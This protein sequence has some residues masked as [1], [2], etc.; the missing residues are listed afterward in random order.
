M[1]KIVFGIVP[2]IL[3]EQPHDFPCF[4]MDLSRSGLS[5][6][7]SFQP[8]VYNSSYV[9]YYR[10]KIDEENKAKLEKDKQEEV[11]TNDKKVVE[12]KEPAKEPVK[13]ET[14][15][16]EKEETK[17]PEVTNNLSDG[18][19]KEPTTPTRTYVLLHRIDLVIKVS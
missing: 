17:S 1:L 12:S 18:N 2:F 6:G 3:H 14:P 7:V 11:Q 5:S 10:R 15:P 19:K 16:K 13:E 4:C 8:R 9:P